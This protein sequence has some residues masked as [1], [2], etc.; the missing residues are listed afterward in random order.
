LLHGRGA[1]EEDLLGL[2]PMLDER[3][4]IVSARAPFAFDFGGYTWYGLGNGTIP[5]NRSFRESCDKLH[6]FILDV[7]TGYNVDLTRVFLFGFSMGSVMSY[8]MALTE[9][10]LVR[11]VSANSGYIPEG[12]HLRFRWQELQSVEFFVTHGIHDSVLPVALGRRAEE[13][14]KASNAKFTYREYPADHQLTEE[15]MQETAEW[16]KRMIG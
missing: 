11:G 2:A 12:S 8:A 9:P 10:G 7:R 13:L 16:L 6:Q 1:D 14:L 5:E 4:F 3:L 15:G